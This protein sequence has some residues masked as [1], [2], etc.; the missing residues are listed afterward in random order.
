VNV[1]ATLTRS[2]A[3]IQRVVAALLA[4]LL[5]VL[6]SLAPAGQ[7]TSLAQVTVWATLSATAEALG[8]EYEDGSWNGALVVRV[9]LQNPSPEGIEGLSVRAVLPA[10][11]Q[12]S[13]GPAPTPGQAAVAVWNNVSVPAASSSIPLE[14]ALVP[15][16]GF[17]GAVVFRGAALTPEI[18]LNGGSV[19]E[20]MELR[21]NGLWGE[22]GLRRTVL[23]TGLTIFSRE[24]L[25]TTTVSIRVAV[26]A[27]SRDEDDTTSGGSHWL[28]HAYF[29]GT[30]QRPN[31]EI[32]DDIDAV[33]GQANASTG[34]ESTDYWKLVPADAFDVAL[35]VLADQMLNSTF[36]EERFDRERRVVFEELKLR[37]DTPSIR[38]FD[39][40]IN[41]A[42]QVSPLQMHPAGTIESVQ[43]IPISTILAHRERHYVTSNIAIAVSGPFPHDAA[44]QAL[45][46]AFA[47][48]PVGSRTPRP[49][50]PEPVQTDL[51]VVEVGDGNRVAEIRLG[52]P[53]PGIQHADLPAMDILDTILSTTE[54]RLSTEIRERRG[55]A[56]SV[57]SSYYA[58]SDAGLLMLSASTQP[59]RVDD[60]IDLLLAEIVRMREGDLTQDAIETAIR[61][62]SGRRALLEE[63]NH[64]QTERAR[65]EV[66]DA[67]ESFDEYLA[68][69]RTVTVAD[70]QR[71]AQTYLDPEHYTLVIVRP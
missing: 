29:L 31:A 36:R 21:L 49:Y 25:E 6:S 14:A 4:T 45:A 40:F 60:V 20:P 70:V 17:D 16:P 55:L 2:G 46:T 65:D 71:V 15:A 67:L 12:L 8:P 27:G 24:R 41:V 7:G 69:L 33:G 42:F 26:R 64:G 61:Y 19:W 18:S 9:T 63:T 52:W 44:V 68:R 54:R 22:E 23:P 47:G 1:L 35:D 37:E 57:D 58:F 50:T 34:W 28:E 38:A 30:E 56:T 51:R 13:N 62:A 3:V 53:V 10:G 39:E 11:V 43:S 66:S 59:N 48:L 32:D 5:V